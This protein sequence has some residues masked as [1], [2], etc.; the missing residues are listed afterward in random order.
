MILGDTAVIP[1]EAG[2]QERWRPCSWV[3][4]FAG[5]TVWARTHHICGWFRS[6]TPFPLTGLPHRTI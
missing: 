5:M 3:P 2:T 4:A 6:E 1:A